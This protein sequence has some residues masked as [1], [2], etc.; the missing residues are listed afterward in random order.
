MAHR[1]AI[2]GALVFLALAGCSS[3]RASSPSKPAAYAWETSTGT[4]A[5]IPALQV[6]PL[7]GLPPDAKVAP[8]VVLSSGVPPLL[9]GSDL[10]TVGWS[11]AGDASRLTLDFAED[12]AAALE[13]W[14]SSYP[15]GRLALVLDGRVITVFTVPGH[16]TNGSLAVGGSQLARYRRA[17]DSATHRTGFGAHGRSA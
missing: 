16:V 1:M 10:V 17:L 4:V 6:V 8:G 5:N 7:V 9:S 2:I 11:G 3:H 13:H 15:E 14:S 12:G